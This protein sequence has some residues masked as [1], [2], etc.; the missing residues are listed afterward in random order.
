MPLWM[1]AKI[2]FAF[3]SAVVHCWIMFSLLSIRPHRPLLPQLFPSHTDS[4]P[5]WLSTL[6]VYL[7]LSLRWLSLSDMFSS[8]GADFGFDWWGYFHQESQNHRMCK[9]GRNHS[10]SSIQ[11]PWSGRVHVT[12]HFVQMFFF[13]VSPK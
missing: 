10:R 1:Q 12:Q 5:Y 2:Q 9:V 8:P 3:V 7:C 6:P 13:L 4:N 11:P